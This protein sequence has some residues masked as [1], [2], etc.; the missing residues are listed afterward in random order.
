MVFFLIISTRLLGLFQQ[1]DKV[2]GK[3]AKNP[4]CTDDL[5]QIRYVTSKIYQIV[6]TQ[7]KSSH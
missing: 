6:S 1:L 7:G 4:S 2:G 5:H 3:A